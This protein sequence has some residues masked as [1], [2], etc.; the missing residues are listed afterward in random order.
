MSLQVQYLHVPVY[1]YFS[2]AS[3][4]ICILETNPN[5][6][7]DDECYFRFLYKAQ[8][9]ALSA[10]QLLYNFALLGPHTALKVSPAAC[11]EVSRP[12][13]VSLSRTQR[14]TRIQPQLARDKPLFS[15]I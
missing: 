8:S 7:S 12:G 3:E 15:Q 9:V 1:F 2:E 11:P 6:I 4:R 14:Q 10:G 5:T 13:V